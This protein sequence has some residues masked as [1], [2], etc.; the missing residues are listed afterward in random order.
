[1]NQLS[2]RA[3]LTWLGLEFGVVKAGL[4]TDLLGVA[5]PEVHDLD[6]PAG[7]R[8]LQQE[9]LGLQVPVGDLHGMQVLHPVH[10]LEGHSHNKGWRD[11]RL[12]SP[13]W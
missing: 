4:G 12:R 5:E 10:H 13:S 8:G 1:M 2:A 7:G 6:D 3:D 11:D 9:V